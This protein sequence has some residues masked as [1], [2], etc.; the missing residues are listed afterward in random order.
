MDTNMVQKGRE[1]KVAEEMSYSFLLKSINDEKM[2]QRI[3]LAFDYY[4][5]NANRCK[6]WDAICSKT[7]VV[8]PAVATLA[9]CALMKFPNTNG[10][11]DLMVPIIT[12]ATSI[13]AGIHS[14]MKYKDKKTAYRDCAENLKNILIAYSCEKGEFGDLDQEEKDELLFN[15]TEQVIL[16]GYKKLGAIENGNNNSADQNDEVRKMLSGKKREK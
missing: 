6:K 2:R 4:I 9:S 11:I 5:Q 12:A 10:I 3:K 13:V 7:L 16:E 1:E 14:A 15:R 8:L